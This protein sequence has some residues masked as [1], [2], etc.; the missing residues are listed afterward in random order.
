MWKI[1]KRFFSGEKAPPQGLNLNGP[2][3]PETATPPQNSGTKTIQAVTLPQ[4]EID[5]PLRIVGESHY[6]ETLEMLCG[7]R[8]EDGADHV[9]LAVLYLEDNNPYDTNAVRIEICNRT[10][11]YLDRKDARAY[12]AFLKRNG[13]P[14]SNGVCKAHIRG[15]WKR[16]RSQGHFGVWLN[17]KLYD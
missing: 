13:T 12:R 15:G 14:K 3:E 16:P 9:A 2:S 4:S 6:Q 5:F 17:F 11:G 10:V 1:L 7:G 8:T